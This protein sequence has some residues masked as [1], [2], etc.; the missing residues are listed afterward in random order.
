MSDRPTAFIVDDD[1]L[2]TG[3]LELLCG[4]M[5]V[6]V[7][8]VAHDAQSA[9]RVLETIDPDYLLLDIRLGPGRDGLDI[10]RDARPG[11]KIVFITGSHEPETLARIPAGRL[12]RLVVKPISPEALSEAFESLSIASAPVRRILVDTM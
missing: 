3:Y 12:H 1:F 10:A 5:D 2:V 8:G 7:L 9:E 11:Q 6:E 4:A